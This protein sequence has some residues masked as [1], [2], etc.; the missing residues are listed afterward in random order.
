MTTNSTHHLLLSFAIAKSGN[1]HSMRGR[2]KLSLNDFA[3]AI[4]DFNKGI[5][6][7]RIIAEFYEDR[8]LVK[9]ELKDSKG[10]FT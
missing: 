8:G 1:A 5:E 10:V 9:A 3:G 2:I 7:N 6:I 4:D